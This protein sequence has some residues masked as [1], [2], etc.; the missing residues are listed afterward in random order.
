MSV[1]KSITKMNIQKGIQQ[2]LTAFTEQKSRTIKKSEVHSVIN[3]EQL[4]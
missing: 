2:T 4:E 1:S 3:L